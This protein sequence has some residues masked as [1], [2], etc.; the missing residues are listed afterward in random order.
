MLADMAQA[1]Q[2]IEL[3]EMYCDVPSGDSDKES[4]PVEDD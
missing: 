2:D 1:T 3:E 4:S